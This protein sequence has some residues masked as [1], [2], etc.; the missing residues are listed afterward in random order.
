MILDMSCDK[1]MFWPG[2]CQHRGTLEKIL[3]FTKLQQIQQALNL[4]VEDVSDNEKGLQMIKPDKKA[5]I[6]Y[7]E[8][9]LY[10][11]PEYKSVSK[12]AVAPKVVVLPKQILKKRPTPVSTLPKKK[13]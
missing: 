10:M 2:H 4:T 9:L 5:T 7:P 6:N 1:F 13:L 8:L 11:L 3:K 12:I